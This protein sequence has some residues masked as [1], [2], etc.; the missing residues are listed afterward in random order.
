M[1]K[2]I[3][4]CID[5]TLEFDTVDECN[6]YAESITAK[7]QVFNVLKYQELPGGRVRVRIQRQYNNS[8]FPAA[9]EGGESNGI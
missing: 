6:R 2:V 5:L 1:K 7:K 3:A 9:M 8:P 4:G